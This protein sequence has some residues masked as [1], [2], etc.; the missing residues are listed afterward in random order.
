MR[1]IWS[2]PVLCI[3][4]SAHAAPPPNSS[5]IFADWFRSLRVPGIPG[6]SCCTVADCRMVEAKWNDLTRHYEARVTREKFSNSLGRPILS[7]EDAEA[8]EAARSAWI[9]RWINK[10]GESPDVWVEIPDAKVNPVQNPTGQAVL[11]W[12]LFNSEF[13]GVYCF[14]PFTAASNDRFEPLNRLV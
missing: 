4:V 12:S 6:A 13:N 1:A 14:M 8:S 3:G 5:G 7:N 11:C 10:Y 2:I 9:N